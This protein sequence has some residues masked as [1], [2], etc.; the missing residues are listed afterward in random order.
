MF[1]KEEG[2]H[3]NKKITLCNSGFNLGLQVS[4]NGQTSN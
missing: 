1:L 4:M 2:Y 3:E